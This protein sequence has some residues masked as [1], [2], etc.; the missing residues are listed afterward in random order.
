[1]SGPKR[2]GRRGWALSAAAVTLVGAGVAAIAV[3]SRPSPVVRDSGPGVEAPVVATAAVRWDDGYEV[4]RSFVGRV[5]ARQESEIGF[6]IGGL[7]SSVAVEEGGSV[8]SGDVVATLDD[9]RLRARRAELAASQRQAIAEEELA[10]LRLRRVSEA[11]ERGAVNPFEWED[12]DREL[13]AAR[14][15]RA[16]ADAAIATI[17]V[18]LEKTVL[19]APFD[20]VVARRSVDA[21]RVIGAGAPVA[22]LLERARPEARIGVGGPALDSIAVGDRFGVAIR[23]RV[24]PGEVVGVLPTRDAAAR[25]VDVVIGLDAELDGI[26]RGDL[27]RIDVARPVEDRGFWAPLESLTEGVRG[28]WSVLA[29]E[30][31]GD[32]WRLRRAEVEALHFEAG[33]VYVRGALDEGALFVSGGLHRVAPGTAVRVEGGLAAAGVAGAAP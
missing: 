6:E 15:R 26:R 11:R 25:G 31:E 29:L 10:E 14:A 20:A 21:G 32:G 4:T 5:E 19:V 8:R 7:V 28:L 23:D 12:A 3:A 30:A 17:D 16:A 9:A 18:D 22:L 27:A 13:A 33:R 2:A 24:V 1:M